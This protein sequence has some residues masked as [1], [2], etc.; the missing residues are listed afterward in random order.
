MSK[1][2]KR[3]YYDFEIRQLYADIKYRIDLMTNPNVSPDM[4]DIHYIIHKII[5]I[6][7]INTKIENAA[8]DDTIK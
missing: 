6:R 1:D 5:E 7:E 3:E 2:D 8:D 4:K